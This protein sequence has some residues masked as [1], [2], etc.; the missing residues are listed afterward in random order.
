MSRLRLFLVWALMLAVPMQGFAAA[1]M[2]WCGASQQLAA[3]AVDARVGPYAAPDAAAHEH[4]AHMH[5]DASA[6][7]AADLAGAPAEPSHSCSVCAACT[8]GVA[9]VETTHAVSFQ[10][11]S[12]SASSELFVLIRARPSAVPEKPPRA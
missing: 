3:G 11:P 4:A 7:P 1:S 12:L 2:L 5:S 6:D 9:I 8:H 10:S